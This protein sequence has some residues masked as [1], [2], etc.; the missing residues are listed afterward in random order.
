MYKYEGKE[1]LP[2][3]Y[4][5]AIKLS[6]FNEFIE[7][8]ENTWH[9]YDNQ[10]RNQCLKSN[11]HPIENFIALIDKGH[12]NGPEVHALYNDGSIRIYNYYSHK[13]ITVL[14]AR[15]GQALRIMNKSVYK[16][17]PENIVKMCMKN[18]WDG[19]NYY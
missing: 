14:M 3:K 19:K 10:R 4:L 15:P 12:K 17:C 7:T 8:S 5:K 16:E 13:F 11:A 1:K 18:Q 2:F 6:E 9:Y